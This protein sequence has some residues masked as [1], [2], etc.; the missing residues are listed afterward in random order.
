[1]PLY[2]SVAVPALSPP[3]DK[4]TVC[5]PQPAELLLALVK[6]PPA[7]QAVPLYSSVATELTPAPST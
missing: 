5:V 3:K 4:A 7:V 2:S 6:F 1:V